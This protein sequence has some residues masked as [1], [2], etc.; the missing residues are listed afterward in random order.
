MLLGLPETEQDVDLEHDLEAQP[1]FKV[2]AL[3]D[4]EVN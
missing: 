1:E 4:D 3:E 2:E